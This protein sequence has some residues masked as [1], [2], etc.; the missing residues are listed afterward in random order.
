MFKSFLKAAV[1]DLISRIPRVRVALEPRNSPPVPSS[2]ARIEDEVPEPEYFLREALQ[3]CD[4]W[5][6][7]VRE[8]SSLDSQTRKEQ[9]EVMTTLL[10]DM[11]YL[12]VSGTRRPREVVFGHLAVKRAPPRR[13]T[14]GP[15]PAGMTDK[16]TNLLL[17]AQR[18]CDYWKAEIGGNPNY[19]ASDYGKIN[20]LG[21]I[22]ADLQYIIDHGTRYWTHPV[23]GKTLPENPKRTKSDI[24]TTKTPKILN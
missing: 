18:C 7:N 21:L 17:E 3:A 15:A 6:L 10:S 13:T 23:R 4:Y 19:V 22:K 24:S 11:A 9:V 12:F 1:H 14:P 2:T 20:C 5:I 16:I 8:D